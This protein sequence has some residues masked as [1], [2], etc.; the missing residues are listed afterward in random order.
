M[1]NKESANA[2]FERN[3]CLVI[4]RDVIPERVAIEVTSKEAVDFAKEMESTGFNGYGVGALEMMSYLT[5]KAF[6]VAVTY[7]NV[8]QE[9]EHER[10]D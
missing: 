4:N 7:Q 1:L 5:K 3:A 8:K 10:E 9:A 2:I 6:F